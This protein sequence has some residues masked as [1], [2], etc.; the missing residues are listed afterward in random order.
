VRFL[1]DNMVPRGVGRVLLR[2]GHRTVSVRRALRQDASD[3]EI[4]AYAVAQRLL[5]VT[6]D[7][8]MARRAR[9]ARVQHVFLRVPEPIAEERVAAAIGDIETLLDGTA[10]RVTVFKAAVRADSS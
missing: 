3:A 2:Q 9:N 7:A 8:G 10:L 5:I 4:V 1:L 6:H